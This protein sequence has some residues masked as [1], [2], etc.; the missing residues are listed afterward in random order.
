ML[1]ASTIGKLTAS[2]IAG[3][4][5]AALAFAQELTGTLKKV[6]ESGTITIGH[7]ES[8]VPSYLMKNSSPSAIR[9]TFAPQSSRK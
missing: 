7:R 5:L 9:W 4:L 3:A 8:S 1:K 2:L 6:K